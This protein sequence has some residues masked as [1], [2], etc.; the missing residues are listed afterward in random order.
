MQAEKL[1]GNAK[2]NYIFNDKEIFE[3][4]KYKMHIDQSTGII[5]MFMEKLQYEDEGTYT[6]QIQDGRA[7]GHSTL[8]LIGDGKGSVKQYL[9]D[10]ATP[11]NA[12]T[13]SHES[14]H[15][16]KSSR[17]KLN[18]SVKNG[19]GNKVANIKKE[20]LIVW[21]KDEREISVDE[22]HDFKDGICTLLITEFSKKDAGIYEVILKDDRGKDKSRL[23]LVDE[24][25]EELM[26][27]VCKTIALSATDLKVQST[28]E[29]IRL[30]SFVTYYLTGP[31]SKASSYFSG[32]MLMSVGQK[33]QAIPLVG[34]AIKYTDRVKSGV[35]TKQIWLQI[36]EPTP[37]DKG[38]YVMELFDG[39]TGHQK[40][41]DLSGE[42]YKEAFDEFQRLKQA[43]IAEKNRARIVGG[44]PDVVTVQEGKMHPTIF[45]V[46]RLLTPD[47]RIAT[48]RVQNAVLN[49]TC[50]VWGNPTPEV[51]W[52]RNEKLLSSDEHCNLRFEAGK[53][54]YFTIS[55]VRTSDSGKYGLVVKNSYG[56]EISDF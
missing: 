51:S 2:V 45:I 44:L 22:K 7:T 13:P 31:T 21:Y 29:G 1:S 18:S 19:S 30:Y 9:E 32:L 12:N 3:G 34:A 27:E 6:F 33:H 40:T 50:T 8:V 26:T 37:N 46:S 52:L 56:S 28:A 14:D 24:A 20:T 49:L 15:F 47:F 55:G 36:N 17:K 11:F 39:K 38:K 53:T 42:V 54:A 41:L 16:I 4:P 25:F 23:K 10:F 43:A 5:E 48:Y 35:T